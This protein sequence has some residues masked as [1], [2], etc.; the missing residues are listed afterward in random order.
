MK[1]SDLGDI[2]QLM[3]VATYQTFVGH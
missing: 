1:L 2:D 3:D